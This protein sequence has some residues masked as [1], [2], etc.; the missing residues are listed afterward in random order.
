MPLKMTLKPGERIIVNGAVLEN[1]GG[2]A[3]LVFLND[4]AF[5]RE[6]DILAEVDALTPAS[7]I[8]FALQCLYIFPTRRDHYNILLSELMEDYLEAAP[9]AQEIV[10]R[11]Q[12]QVSQGEFYHAL[13]TVRALI[14]HEKERL[15]NVSTPIE[16]LSDATTCGE[17][18]SD[19]GL[20]AS[21]S[22][23]AS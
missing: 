19:T 15:D 7:R 20:G 4:A 2:E 21:S 1:G 13:K 3:H 18:G 22:G 10:E 5:M 9:S 6:K 16:S 11:I 23:Q 14:A 12:M 8:Y 17:P